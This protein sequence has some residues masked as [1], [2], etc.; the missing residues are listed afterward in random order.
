MKADQKVGVKVEIEK[1]REGGKEYVGQPVV[2]GGR[3]RELGGG[4]VVR[5]REGENSSRNSF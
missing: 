5:V 1:D 4:L 2:E 3:E